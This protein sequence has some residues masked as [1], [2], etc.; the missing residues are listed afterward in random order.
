MSILLAWLVFRPLAPTYAAI[1]LNQPANQSMAVKQTGPAVSG[2]PVRLV[3]PALSIDLPTDPGIYN[4][5]SD[6]WTLSGYH[7]QYALDSA[8]ANNL[9]G[10]TFIYGH[11]NPYVF[12]NMKFIHPGYQAMVITDNGHEFLYTYRTTNALGPNATGI[13]D[14]LGPP[15]L[16]VQTCS[17]SFNQYRQ[18]YYFDFTKVVK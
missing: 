2:R 16:T 18:M 8:P 15:V 3:I 17:G 6:S 1:D 7:A 10:E 14:Y 4:A 12:W 9:G 11:N 5:N 13:L